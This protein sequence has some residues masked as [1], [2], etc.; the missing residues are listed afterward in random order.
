MLYSEVG[1]S[2]LRADGR[3]GHLIGLISRSIKFD[4]WVRNQMKIR[5][6]QGF[7]QVFQR[8]GS[9]N[10]LEMVKPGWVASGPPS[11]L[12]HKRSDRVLTPALGSARH[13]GSNPSCSTK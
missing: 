3:C 6:G 11:F 4:S 13:E 9:E 7:G 8:K 2:G 12:G 5:D 1:P 10:P